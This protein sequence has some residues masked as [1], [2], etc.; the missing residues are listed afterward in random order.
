MDPVKTSE[1]EE[2]DQAMQD[3]LARGNEIQRLG[4]GETGM[5]SLSVRRR[6]NP[7]VVRAPKKPERERLPRIA[8][9]STPAKPRVRKP[10]PPKERTRNGPAVGREGTQ[11]GEIL[12]LLRT[13]PK[14]AREIAAAHNWKPAFVQANLMA[15]RERKAVKATGLRR[16]PGMR[17]AQGW[18]LA[19]P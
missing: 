8:R 14:T 3:Y 5:D 16:V 10:K 6:I 12:K 11:T 18:V 1:R 17:P 15:L 2:L 13:G 7:T 9:M 4:R 19:C